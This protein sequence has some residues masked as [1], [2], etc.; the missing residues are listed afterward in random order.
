M[1]KHE[2][3]VITCYTGTLLCDF[4]DFHEQAEKIMGRPVWTHEFVEPSLWAELKE[5][6]K[7][8]LMKIIGELQ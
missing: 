5:K 3:A 8:E 4:A 1:T 6:A 2:A 7:P